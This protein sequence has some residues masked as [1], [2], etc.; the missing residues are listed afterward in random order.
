MI[1]TRQTCYGGAKKNTVPVAVNEPPKK[2]NVAATR[3][4]KGVLA[5]GKEN[6]DADAMERPIQRR[7]FEKTIGRGDDHEVQCLPFL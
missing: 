4:G 2:R 6:V 3:Q 5:T 7:R 1:A